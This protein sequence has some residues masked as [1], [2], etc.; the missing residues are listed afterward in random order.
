MASGF[1]VRR[2]PAMFARRQPRVI[3]TARRLNSSSSVQTQNPAYPLY[4]SVIQLLH[5]KGIP[6]SDISKIPASGPKGRLLKGDVLAY[7]GAIPADYPSS[8]ASRLTKLSHLDLSNI[9]IAAPP[10]P[11]E[12]KAPVVE[13]IA[14]PPPTVS[15]AISVSLATVLSA[16]KKIKETLG[17]TVPLSTFLA[18]ATDLANDDLPRSSRSKPSADELFDEILGAEPIKTS[19]GDYFPELNALEAVPVQSAQSYKKD[20]IDILSG[21][22]SKKAPRA[23]FVEDA[24][25]GSAANVF[26]LTVPVGDE[27]RA[28]VFLDRVKTLLTIEPGRLVL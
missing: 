4:P 27:N 3:S 23:A 2:I 10:K 22:V 14:R 26:S 12:P 5:E 19:R 20:I 17:V 6:E 25:V 7:I 15:V 28:K 16:Q 8:Q 13:E 18:R 21:N 1:P 11:A 24:P 9:K